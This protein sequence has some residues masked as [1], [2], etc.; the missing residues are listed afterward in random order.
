MAKSEKVLPRSSFF[1]FL[2]SIFEINNTMARVKSPYEILG[3]TRLATQQEIRKRYLELC[4]KHHPDV[5][6]ASLTEGGPDIRDITTA[7]QYLTGKATSTRQ[8]DYY[9][10]DEQHR[11]AS[12]EKQQEWTKH[13]LWA[14]VGIMASVVAYMVYEPKYPDRHW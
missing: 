4:K 8:T 13:S 6:R 10:Q 12:V 7:Y 9:A 14:G 11:Q 3:V 1:S 2:P 5:A